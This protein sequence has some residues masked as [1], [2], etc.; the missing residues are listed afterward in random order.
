MCFRV[1]SQ[2]LLL[3]GTQLDKLVLAYQFDGFTTPGATKEQSIQA[4]L[5]ISLVLPTFVGM[6]CGS[7]LCGIL[8]CK[9]A[10]TDVCM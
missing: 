2:F 1:C 7:L 6:K 5:H 10:Y 8:W 4:L 9:K 3:L